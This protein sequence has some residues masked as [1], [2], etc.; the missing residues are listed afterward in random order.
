M[1]FN[2]RSP[3][4]DARH[5]EAVAKERRKLRESG[6]QEQAAAATQYQA[7]AGAEVD[8]LTLQAAFSSFQREL[9]GL[10]TDRYGLGTVMAGFET[11]DLPLPSGPFN[12]RLLVV[13][14]ADD[15]VIE[16]KHA[17]DGVVTFTMGRTR[18]RFR[19]SD[20]AGESEPRVDLMQSV[21]EGDERWE[22]LHELVDRR[23]AGLDE[24]VWRTE[25]ASAMGLD[26]SSSPETDSLADTYRAE[27]DAAGFDEDRIVAL[28]ERIERDDR[29]PHLVAQS[30]LREA[31]RRLD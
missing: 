22:A 17:G 15:L 5:A 19:P 9:F 12:A 4:N 31:E 25:V 13:D 6:E 18:G 24:T 28:A 26:A 23:A 21:S 3:K 8:R 14:D 20:L 1:R 27:L 11:E 2:I 29:L 30:L 7:A 16:C 10:L